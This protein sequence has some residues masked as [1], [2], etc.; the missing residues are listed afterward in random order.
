MYGNPFVEIIS[1]LERMEVRLD[2]ISANLPKDKEVAPTKD[3]NDILDTRAIAGILCVPEST[4]RGYINNKVNRLPV[5]KHGK[6]YRIKRSDLQA[7]I[8]DIYLTNEQSVSSG[9]DE[10]LEEKTAPTF[11]RA[12]HSKNSIH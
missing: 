9:C 11:M 10:V 8:N 7:W 1:K 3:P 4:V 12:I 6:G 2:I 5:S